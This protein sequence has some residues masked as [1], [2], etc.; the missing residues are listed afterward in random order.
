MS[1][2]N[3]QNIDARTVIEEDKVYVFTSTETG[4]VLYL[5]DYMRYE[6]VIFMGTSYTGVVQLPSV[7][8]AKGMTYTIRAEDGTNACTLRDADDSENWSDQSLDETD[9]CIIVTSDGHAWLI[10]YTNLS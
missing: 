9:D 5:R 2:L 6:T 1:S 3:K 8:E 10:T 7:A 4:E